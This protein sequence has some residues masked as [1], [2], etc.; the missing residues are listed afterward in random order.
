MKSG[1][2]EIVCRITGKRYI[3]SSATLGKRKE[4]H[5]YSLRR[6]RHHSVKLQRAWDKYGEDSFV[7]NVLLICSKQMLLVYEQILIDAYSAVKRGY[8]IA[9]KAGSRAGVKHSNSTIKL[10]REKQRANRKRYEWNGRKLCLAE[11]AEATG[12][13]AS[14]LDRR[15]IT[16][17]WSIEKAVLTPRSERDRAYVF[18]GERLNVNAFAAKFGV[19]TNRVRSAMSAGKSADECASDCKRIS[20]TQL[21]DQLGLT[22]FTVTTRVIAGWSLLDALTVERGSS[23]RREHA[24]YGRAGGISEMYVYD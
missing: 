6:G 9:M 19:S 14:L 20:I 15:V 16:D 5:L 24:V 3:G 21:A 1:V 22:S 7:F 13:S 12:V 11:I 23:K 8:N 4:S 10:M 17:G 2:Y 18:D